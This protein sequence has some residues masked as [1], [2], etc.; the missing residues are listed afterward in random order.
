M[1]RI[2][3][4]NVHSYIMKDINYLESICIEKWL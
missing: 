4:V 3:N 2:L 1:S